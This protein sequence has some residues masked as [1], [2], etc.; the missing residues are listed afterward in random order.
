[1][2]KTKDYLFFWGGILS[3]WAEVPG[4]IKVQDEDELL[5][6]PTSEHLF[7]WFKASFFFDI[8][9]MK[10]ILKAKT[11][12]EAKAIGRKVKNFD[13]ETW[14]EN[15]EKFMLEAL[16]YK[17]ESWPEFKEFVIS[18]P[19]TFV[20]ASPYD[21]IWGIGLGE[22]SPGIDN[23]KNWAGLNLLGKCLCKLREYYENETTETT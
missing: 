6:F 17:A 23:P 10:K 12:K 7:M 22:D 11:P 9:S 20:E 5:T 8:D 3:N 18:T 14:E 1:M 15:R 4:G 13:E 21:R 16:R 2:K 19:Q